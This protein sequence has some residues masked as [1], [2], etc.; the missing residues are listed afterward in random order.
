M[1]PMALSSNSRPPRT[2]VQAMYVHA[3]LGVIAYWQ[4]SSFNI[5]PSRHVNG[6]ASCSKI[7]NKE[8]EEVSD[9][10]R[11]LDGGMDVHLTKFRVQRQW[12][13]IGTSITRINALSR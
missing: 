7:G 2:D 12:I 9:D 11:F 4:L 3:R 1:I 8:F 13:R 5:T 6:L 10:C